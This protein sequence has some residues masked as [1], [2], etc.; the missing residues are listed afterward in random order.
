MN[1]EICPVDASHTPEQRKR[2]IRQYRAR[3]ER[4]DWDELSD[5]QKTMVNAYGW[6]EKQR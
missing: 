1:D 6:P 4:P 2:I 3:K 5:L